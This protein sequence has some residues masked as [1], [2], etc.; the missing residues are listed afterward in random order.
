MLPVLPMRVSALPYMF[1]SSPVWEAA[2]PSVGLL[3]FCWHPCTF[4]MHVGVVHL[5]G[6]QQRTPSNMCVPALSL[7]VP[8]DEVSGFFR[9]KQPTDVIDLRALLQAAAPQQ[10]ARL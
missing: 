10:Q 8:V 9:P 6:L 3:V 2:M 1:L 4:R 7:Q 5:T